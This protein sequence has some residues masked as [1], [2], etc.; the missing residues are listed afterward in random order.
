VNAN[1]DDAEIDGENS[2]DQSK[3]SS[4]ASFLFVATLLRNDFS[5]SE[6]FKMEQINEHRKSYNIGLRQ[7]VG[8]ESCKTLG[9]HSHCRKS[10]YRSCQRDVIR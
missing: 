4:A 7:G 6:T 9:H 10:Q 8:E 3:V 2:G 5:G 1:Q